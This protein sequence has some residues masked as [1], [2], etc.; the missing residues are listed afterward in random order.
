MTVRQA[1]L[2]AM[3][4]ALNDG[5]PAPVAER[6]RGIES[7]P[8]S[9]GAM[10]ISPFEDVGVR[11]G[12]QSVLMDRT[13]IAAVECR[14]IASATDT[15]TENLEP[16]LERVTAKL[17]GSRLGGLVRE[18]LDVRIKFEKAQGDV[19]V[20]KATAFVTAKYQTLV[21]DATRRT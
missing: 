6:D 16:L 4:T 2:E 15:A 9:T 19:R 12:P 13:L 3:L 10:T 20:A 7:V 1:I 5:G 18:T 11:I 21:N 14:A 17:G 8:G